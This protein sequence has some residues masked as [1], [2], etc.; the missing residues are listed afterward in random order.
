MRAVGRTHY[1]YIG[2]GRGHEGIWLSSEKPEPFL[3]KRDTFLE[4]IRKFLSAT[5][6]MALEID[7]EDRIIKLKYQ[8]WRVENTFA[9]FYKGRSLYFSHH[10]FNSKQSY[11]LDKYLFQ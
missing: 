10:F 2:R 3:R 6:F 11:N 1:L 8:K 9:I 7:E 4:Y 5:Q